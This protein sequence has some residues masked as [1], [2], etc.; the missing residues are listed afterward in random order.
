MPA[1]YLPSLDRL[2]ARQH[3]VF[4]LLA[5]GLSN[6]EIG[7]ALG[8][9]V[10]T[11]KTHVARIFNLLEVSTRA[12]AAGLFAADLTAEN[13]DSRVPGFGLC[14]A[15]AVM[16]FESLGEDGANDPLCR[17]I[18]EDLIQ[19]LS[20]WRLFPV[21]SRSSTWAYA[22]QQ[23]DLRSVGRELGVAYCVEGTIRRARDR[24]QL[25][26]NLVDTRSGQ[27]VWSDRFEASN[28]EFIEL[29]EEICQL[30]ASAIF[31]N[32]IQAE[33]N[34]HN[35]LETKSLD[36]WQA[37]LRGLWTVDRMQSTSEYNHE[38]IK[39]F[40]HAIKTDPGFVLPHYGRV[41]AYNQRITNAWDSEPLIAIQGLLE[42]AERTNQVD[43]LDPRT[44]CANGISL[45]LQG[46][47]TA[48]ATHLNRAIEINPSDVTS[49]QFSAV[50][51]S[52]SQIDSDQAIINARR[53]VRLSRRSPLRAGYL[54]TLGLAHLTAGEEEDGI[55]AVNESVRLA[56][57]S[58]G[59]IVWQALALA[60]IG[61]VA[62]TRGALTRLRTLRPEMPESFIAAFLTTTAGSLYARAEPI[63]AKAGFEV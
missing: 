32:L 27:M 26:A 19:R 34:R 41:L 46:D 40:D 11:V 17:G 37:S 55:E 18:V 14:P 42:A 21:L 23:W 59:L 6:S 2:T 58:Y 45:A 31:P 52:F 54:N 16:P 39:Q 51:L 43:P 28:A 12:E 35:T 15:I 61:D 49:L 8:I 33:V 20:W 47:K 36:A 1:S 10:A 60:A 7:A 57:N 62:A 22:G 29:Q 30:V 3:E 63:L 38:A 50:V 24:Y 9:G 56:P 44:F 4:E 53:A 25:T 13:T 5:K 48:S